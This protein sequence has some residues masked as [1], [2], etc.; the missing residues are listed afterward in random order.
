MQLKLRIEQDIDVSDPRKEFDHIGTMV[1]WHRRYNLGDVDGLKEYG[2]S[3][4]FLKLLASDY[5]DDVSEMSMDEVWK[6][7][8]DWFVILPL[9]LLD[10]SGLHMWVGS[11]PHACDCGGWDSGQ[12]GWIYC[13]LGKAQEE[14]TSAPKDHRWN[15]KV[16]W[17][18]GEVITLREAI[19]RNLKAEV[20]EY[21]M[22]LTGDVWGYV[23]EDEDGNHM[24]SCWGF[25]GHKYA[26]EQGKEMLEHCQKKQDDLE[27][28]TA[29]AECVP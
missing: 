18:G 24:E 23:I 9:A 6:I 16:H 22:F 20:E 10:H 3:E 12:V 2:T 8:D 28:E 7:I 19:E 5:V 21:D 15:A 11:G 1:Y 26:E 25:Y 14:W 17:S 4:M 13:S 27:R 29:I